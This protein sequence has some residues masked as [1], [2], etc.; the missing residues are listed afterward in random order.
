MKVIQ[1][2]SISDFN[3][4]SGAVYTQKTIMEECKEDEFD[5]L[6]EDLYPD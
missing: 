4:W 6:I 1:E 3:A 5:N 2:V